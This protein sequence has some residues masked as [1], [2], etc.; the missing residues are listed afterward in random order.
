MMCLYLSQSVNEHPPMFAETVYTATVN[1][2]ID[3]GHSIGV[4]VEATD[5][6]EGHSIEYSID[7]SF[8]DGDFF[9]IGSTSG[10]ITL[11]RSLD[12]DPPLVHETFTFIV[13]H[14]ILSSPYS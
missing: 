10:E 8:Q 14:H 1:E 11:A 9:N 7:N 13:S 6:L 3:V 2:D 12:R 5:D 4:T